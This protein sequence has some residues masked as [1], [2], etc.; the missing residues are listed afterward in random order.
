MLN[1]NIRGKFTTF[2][3]LTFRDSFLLVLLAS[4][5]TFCNDIYHYFKTQ[6]L[7]IDFPITSFKNNIICNQIKNLGYF[8]DYDNSQCIIVIM[9]ELSNIKR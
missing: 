2:V 7:I 6:F 3:I 1:L 5:S 9:Y 8:C 4:F